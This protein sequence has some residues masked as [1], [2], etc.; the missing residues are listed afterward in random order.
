MD[1]RTR[2]AHHEAA[3]AVANAKFGFDPGWVCLDIGQTQFS[4]CLGERSPEDMLIPL[5]AGYAAAIKV[6]PEFEN[7]ARIGA[8]DDFKR[9]EEI[10]KEIGN[11]SVELW[12]AKAKVFV[13]DNW[14][15][16][17]LV[18]AELLRSNCIAAEI[19]PLIRLAEG[20]NEAII[21]LE[22]IR[23]SRKN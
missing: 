12:I 15:A 20:D 22:E 6:A 9:A 17:Q 16:I 21:E 7:E 2:V 11:S 5:Y 13:A 3:H 4:Y 1:Q 23:L 18:A 14:K 19:D 8:D 10:I